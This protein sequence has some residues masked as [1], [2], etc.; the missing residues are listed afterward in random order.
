MLH[1]LQLCH[2]SVPTSIPSTLLMQTGAWQIAI[3]NRS[4]SLWAQFAVSLLQCQ[5][6]RGLEKY[7]IGGMSSRER[8]QNLSSIFIRDSL[9][10]DSWW[11]AWT[12]CGQII[13]KC[14]TVEVTCRHSLRSVAKSSWRGQS[15]MFLNG[16]KEAIL[17][18]ETQSLTRLTVNLGVLCKQFHMLHHTLRASTVYKIW[19]K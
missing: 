12:G 2:P 5:I 11:S 4:Y 9:W 18:W 10:N 3:G 19:I 1:A 8:E 16:K 17:N 13:I 6:A 7:V 14:A 15:R